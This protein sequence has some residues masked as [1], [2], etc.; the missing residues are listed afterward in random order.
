MKLNRIKLIPKLAGVVVS[1]GMAA[2]ASAESTSLS[3]VQE[4]LIAQ[5]D[6]IENAGRGQ[7]DPN[8]AYPVELVSGIEQTLTGTMPA[9]DSWFELGSGYLHFTSASISN[10][11]NE[12][13]ATIELVIAKNGSYV[14]NGGFIGFGGTTRGFWAYQ[15][16]TLLTAYSYHARAS[17]EYQ[18]INYNADG[19]NTVYFLLGGANGSAS[20]YGANGARINNVTRFSTDCDDD[21]YIGALSALPDTRPTAQVFSIRVYNRIL[22]E[23]ELRRNSRIDKDRFI[24]SQYPKRTFYVSPTGNDTTGDGTKEKPFGTIGK[25][26]GGC[27]DGDTIVL[28]KG[29]HDLGYTTQITKD[30]VIRGETENPWDTVINLDRTVGPALNV[31]NEFARI[32]HLAVTNTAGDTSTGGS[33]LKLYAGT[34]TNCV[35]SQCNTSGWGRGGAVLLSGVN[36]FLVDS[37]I[38][39]CVKTTGGDNSTGGLILEGGA[40]AE[41]CL[42]AFNEQKDKDGDDASA[43][44]VRVANGH[45]KDCTIVGNKGKRTGGLTIKEGSAVNCII[46][47][48]VSTANG[49]AYNEVYPGHVSRVTDS[50]TSPETAVDA[51]CVRDLPVNFYM[52]LPAGDIRPAA[53]PPAT[54]GYFAVDP[55][56]PKVTMKLDATK[57]LSPLVVN[58]QADVQGF[59]PT[60]EVEYSWSFGGGVADRT[61]AK[62]AS[63][64]FAAGTFDVSL[65]VNNLTTGKTCRDVKP[66]LVTVVPK[67]VYVDGASTS[68]A[69]PYDAPEKAAKTLKDVLPVCGEGTEVRIV[70]NEY[71]EDTVIDKSV[72]IVGTGASPEDVRQKKRWTIKAPGVQIAGVTFTGCTGRFYVDSPNA[73]FTNC[74]F[75]N[76]DIGGGDANSPL[77]IMSAGAL[78]THCVFSNNYV[79]ASYSEEYKSAGGL[80]ISG[81]V[82]RESLFWKNRGTTDAADKSHP[83]AVT[84]AGGSQMINCTVADNQALCQKNP[85][86]GVRIVSGS[87]VNCAIV[88]NR[89]GNYGADDC[90]N[91]RP[92]DLQYCT[93]CVIGDDVSVFENFA[94]GLLA[95][96]DDALFDA[97]AA[98]A[99]APAKDLGGNDR[100]RGAAIDIGCYERDPS[101]FTVSFTADK[102]SALAPAAFTLTASYAV[103]AGDT[104]TYDWEL[105]N[106]MTVIAKSVTNDPY[107]DVSLETCGAWDVSLHVANETKQIA[108]SVEVAAFLKVDPGTLFV[109]AGNEDAAYPYDDPAKGAAT[110]ADAVSAAG[111]GATIYIGAGTY[112]TAITLT[113]GATL[114][115]DN[116]CP[117]NVKLTKAVTV[118]APNVRLS[119]ITL[120]PAPGG[121]LYDPLTV[122]ATGCTLS[123]CVIRNCMAG[124]YRS[125][126]YWTG[127]GGLVTHCA[128]TN[129][130]VGT[131][132]QGSDCVPPALYLKSGLVRETLFWNNRVTKDP[133][134]DNVL[135]AGAVSLF[136]GSRMENCTLAA[137]V[138]TRVGG[139][140]I[141]SGCTVFNTIVAGNTLRSGEAS[142]VLSDQVAY[143]TSCAITDD[144]SVFEDF[145]AGKLGP[146][147]SPLVYDAGAER[148][149]APAVDLAGAPRIQGAAIDLG[150]YER[151]PSKFTVSFTAEKTVLAAPSPF[152]LHA[153]CLIPEGHSAT[154]AWR[155][156]QGETT[157]SVDRTDDPDATVPLSAYG[158][159]NVSLVVTDTTSGNS[160]SS[161]AANF[162]KLVPATVYAKAGNENA[163]A[164]YE[165]EE[166]AAATIADACSWAAADGQQ[167]VLLPGVYTNNGATVSVGATL[168]GQTGNPEDVIVRMGKITLDHA[169]AMVCDVVFE[170]QSLGNGGAGAE[171]TAQGGIVSN[172]VF[173]NMSGGSF[174]SMAPLQLSGANALAT[175]CVF[176]NNT[177]KPPLNQACAG[178]AILLAGARIE[179]CLIADNRQDESSA[180]SAPG[181]YANPGLVVNCTVV[182]NVSGTVA[183]VH[184]ANTS[185]AGARRVV[186]TVMAGNV[187]R[188]GAGNI[189]QTQKAYYDHCA[190][191]EE[192]INAPGFVKAPWEEMFDGSKPRSPYLPRV[193]GPLY[194]TGDGTAVRDATDL[195]GYRRR[196]G[197]A[198]DIGAF[199]AP[200]LGFSILVR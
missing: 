27:V 82:V 193:R 148:P 46:A 177:P 121:E 36:A 125:T 25:G 196:A 124:Y 192:I 185:S 132:F 69:S 30:I 178:G 59:A 55:A 35:F 108:A 135:V 120:T 77:V 180:G 166:T 47:G 160:A 181:V 71:S 105:R 126:V 80:Y 194:N 168:R 101:K 45:L 97:G 1:L 98:R 133:G 43:G 56:E 8:A 5:W 136:N 162:L 58:F 109:R 122:D 164:P 119:G 49:A 3:Y 28:M 134:G 61:D 84:L 6:G 188:N 172:C 189:E 62:A 64:T 60:D 197:K 107:L 89:L 9:H 90:K 7:H 142:N 86:G 20:S 114:V 191:D 40:R 165:T 52:N 11:L 14:H 106:G 154:Y 12:G 123:N 10:A 115:G 102:E 18:N 50:A 153:S 76:A 155:I 173:R 65:C 117:E 94:N 169:A 104:V 41:K 170:G 127:S 150:C 140:V 2:S 16:G 66:A 73:V 72:C 22:T 195:L 198:V 161:E 78:V 57:G 131:I 149:D 137:N 85:V 24:R 145:A 167:I 21:C 143:C 138:G 54:Y 179:N 100:I 53:Q 128:F 147:A 163:V 92:E 157:V 99:D 200:P 87:A 23:E 139:L 81:G 74:V 175:H 95:P 187:S 184:M 174:Y 159:W 171:A 130:T 67:T 110:L 113:K 116:A 91:V 68:P 19:T 176:T 152:V 79:H 112:S 118:S 141:G 199:E 39:N 103:P 17:G 182:R 156:T 144:T 32:E 88:G 44:G 38:S 158:E 4:G 26:V 51:T 83:G 70:P 63:V 190:V 15:Q 111:A 151:D 48:N 93:S 34:A 37:V 13:H 183:G 29:R 33:A 186:N 42:I 75:R 146:S 129:N 96:S 31:N